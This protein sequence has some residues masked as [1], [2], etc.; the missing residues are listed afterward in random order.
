M[1]KIDFHIHTVAS[2]LDASFEFSQAKLDEYIDVA[3]LDCIAVT[4]HNLF[5]KKQ[6]TAIRDHI[7]IPIFPGI[8]VDLENGQIL[9]FAD[10]NGVDEFGDRCAQ[11]SEKWGGSESSISVEDFKNVFGDLS[12]YL[13]IPHYEKKPSIDEYTLSELS[14]FVTAG[15]VS[16]PK[17][18]MYC[19]KSDERLV[20]VYFSDCRIA[21]KL[22]PLPTRQT[23]L[24]CS[25]AS[26][27]AVK[28]CLR[29][30]N[31]VALSR[32]DGNRLFQIFEN[33]QLLSTGLNVVLGDRSSG[34]SHT[35][36]RIKQ[37]F[38]EAYHI[39]Q[40]AL[41]ARDAQEDEKRFNTYLSQKQGLFSKEYLL[42]LQ[43]VI[44]DVLDIELDDD[45]RG[46]ERY[47]SSLL[48]FAKETE[49]HDAFSKA[50]IYSE[51]PFLDRNQKGLEDLIASTKNLISNEEFKDIVDKHLHRE[52]LKALYI[53][54][55]RTH[56][57]RE[58]LRLKRSWV[59]EL[60][61]NIK[62]KLQLRSAA[63][64]IVDVDL[65][66]VALNKHKIQRFAKMAKLARSRKTPL[67]KQRRGFTVVAEVGSFGGAGELKAVIK[68]QVAFSQAFE[69][70]EDPYKFLQELKS[71][72][73]PVT[74]ADFSK[75]FVKIDYRILNKDGFDASGGE[76]SEFFLL[77]EIEGAN[78]H[79][80]LLIDEPESSFDNNFLK[81]DVNAM[82]KELSGKMPVVVVTH[83]NTVGASIKPDYLLC[84]RKELEDGEVVWTTYSGYPTSKVL[85]SPDGKTLDTLDVMMGNLE[86]GSDAYDDR[87]Q[88]YENL[89]D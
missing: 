64:K 49:K 1:I 83:N 18:F 73:D 30:K 16:S 42:G 61:Q 86:A 40:F 55:M 81:D 41:V 47:I 75:F 38:P 54:L 67:K 79:E 20:P 24:D 19:A 29:D 57:A 11:I 35:L 87:R 2:E 68:R 31:K 88:T 71:I 32:D 23:F 51:D 63:P 7:N 76:R 50:K 10:G 72:G 21:S 17:K 43:Q 70:Y 27:S 48:N 14:P 46:V 56:A 4:N 6:F 22:E 28:E 26:F 69:C 36:K 13:L 52:S 84:T 25:E 60:T 3:E 12:R 82:I 39:E 66:S 80:M 8:E 85:I 65:Y 53:D 9:V 77:D 33:G 89:K 44:E 5:D 45:E 58:E 74:P 34:K 15:E 37:Q 78:E 62:S 59:N